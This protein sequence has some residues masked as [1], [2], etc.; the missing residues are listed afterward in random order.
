[1]VAV[2]LDVILAPRLG[3]LGVATATLAGFGLSSI[4]LYVVSQRVHPLPF[5][6]LRALVLFL[7]GLAALGA[8]FALDR[9]LG[10]GTA[11][12]AMRALVFAAYAAMAFFL[13]RRLPP[14]FAAGAV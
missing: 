5:R 9:S 6:G 7:L 13:A 2:A 1:L 8:G 14:P 3:L 10:G 4:A 11:G 12:L